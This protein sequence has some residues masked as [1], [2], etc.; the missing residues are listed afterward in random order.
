MT[1]ERLKELIE[2]EET[3][4]DSELREIKLKKEMQINF[5]CFDDLNDY[6]HKEKYV[7]ECS[8]EQC[9]KTWGLPYEYYT[10]DNL[11]DIFENKKDAQKAYDEKY[12]REFV[13]IK[14]ELDE[15]K[16]ILSELCI[17]NK[18]TKEAIK[19]G[20]KIAYDPS[21]KGYKNIESL[22][23]SLMV[24][25]PA[26]TQDG[27]QWNVEYPEVFGVGG[28]GNNPEE[29]IK[30]AQQNLKVHLDFL[31]KENKEGE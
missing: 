12:N 7:L 17:P 3:I 24:V 16:S 9:L 28:A 21:V 27:I 19:D 4:Y 6:S 14:K 1:L 13:E 29:A 8:C 23:D 31:S 15:I 10:F 22:K 18:E 26:E 11:D 20:I 5:R 30:D 2:K 25:Y